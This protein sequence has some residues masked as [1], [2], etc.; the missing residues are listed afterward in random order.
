MDYLARMSRLRERLEREGLDALFVTNLTNIRYLCG[1]TGS[2]AQLLVGA[3]SATFFSD[4]RYRTQAGDEVEEA[5]VEIYPNLKERP[6]IVRAAAQRMKVARLGFESA[7]VPVR[8]REMPSPADGLPDLEAIFER[9]QLLPTADLVED[10]R[11]V[12]EPEELALIRTAAEMA[13]DGFAYILEQVQV[14]RTE[15]EVALDLEFYLRRQGADGVSFEPIVAA[16]ERS[17]LPHARPTGRTVEKGRYL[18]F[19]LGCV[20][21]GYCSDLTRTVV[22]GPADDRHREVYEV[23]ARANAAGI[24]AARPGRKGA[25]VDRS[26]REVIAA[27]G[28]PEAFSH[29]L[30]HGVGIEVHEQPRLST[31]SEHELEPGEV[32]TIEPGAYFPGWG[33]VRIE[34]LV[35]LT[36]DGVDV[37][38]R[39]PKDLIVL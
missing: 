22:V 5:A 24:D 35:V 4:G 30:G 32:V 25:E 21:R 12:K 2:S 26:A 8:G 28:Y 31:I 14:G 6:P 34:D 3:E 27:A 29:G 37:L 9:M 17:A 10:L 7:Y 33:G 20:Y 1:F 13:D 23:V 36:A 11:R 18:L 19:D 39:S 15:R 38:S 16:A